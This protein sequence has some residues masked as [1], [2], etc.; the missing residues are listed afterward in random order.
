M[1]LVPGVLPVLITDSAELYVHLVPG[2]LIILHCMCVWYQDTDS[3][4]LYVP[5]GLGLQIE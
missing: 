2:L 4:Q 5:L 3:T 1:R